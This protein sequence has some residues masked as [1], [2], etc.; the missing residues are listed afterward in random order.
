MT[1]NTARGATRF[2][3]FA[4]KNT[5]LVWAAA[6]LLVVVLLVIALPWFL[7]SADATDAV[8]QLQGPSG[9]HLLG[10]DFYGRDVLSR[11]V[12]GGR[13]SLGL[14]ILV[15]LC[16][17]TLGAI[18]GMISGYFR[19]ADQILMR[20]MDAWMAFPALILAM[21]LAIA[22]GPGMVT[23]L[24]SLTV[25]FTP[26]TARVIRAMVL[27]LSKRTFIDA[28]RAS[29]MGPWKILRVHVF[30]HVLPLA[31]VQVV[32]LAAAALLVD[33][34]M[35]FLGL[36]IAPP[37]PTW[38]N[39]IAEGRTY[40]ST[41]P[42]LIIAPGCAIVVCVLLLNILGGNLRALIDPR[43]RT[44]ADL[45]RARTMR[46]AQAKPVAVAAEAAPDAVAKQA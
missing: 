37:T 9:A 12:A 39:I 17:V 32:I 8:H 44:L 28:A 40:M 46:H 10:T 5:A 2:R 43:S 22:L 41:S 19:T 38:G 36:G 25:I 31:L 29:G 21:S 15:T 34:A 45:Q 7:P 13:A 33:A 4:Q 27:S 35:S 1:A 26:F 16:A 24:I 18:I 42:L 23:E 11:L 30:P 20:V 3:A 6:G 14:S